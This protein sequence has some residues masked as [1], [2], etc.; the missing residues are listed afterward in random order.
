M[1]KFSWYTDPFLISAD[2]LDVT[3][4]FKKKVRKL[5][6]NTRLTSSNV[7]YQIQSCDSMIK[8]T[9]STNVSILLY[10]TA[11]TPSQ[12]YLTACVPD[13]LHHSSG[14]KY[15]IQNAQFASVKIKIVIKLT[16]WAT[17]VQHIVTF[18]PTV[19]TGE[20]IMK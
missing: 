16:K 7:F 2:I 19:W 18:P 10:S 1:P 3:L 11:T 12:L 13:A 6:F 8:S 15:L 20:K 17:A 4:N 5:P 9:I 14:L